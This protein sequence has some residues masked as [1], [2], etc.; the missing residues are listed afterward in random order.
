MKKIV[1]AM[2][3][4]AASFTAVSC[5][6]GNAAT[7]IKSENLAK[8]VERDK[9]INVGAPE[10]SFDKTEFDFGTAT[11]GDVIKTSF[12]VT[13][14][15]KSDLIISKADATCG[16]T[17]PEWP[18]EAIAPGKTG[19]IKVSFNTSGKVGK[20]SKT[21]TL[22]TNTEKGIETVKIGGM[23]KAKSKE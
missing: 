22:R 4:A 14:T 15:G 20:Q 2:A 16:C 23:V 17:V 21:V 5:S 10:I 11:D 8:A 1:Y 13:N 18:K 7:K 12:I 9:T 3:I 19:E 6:N